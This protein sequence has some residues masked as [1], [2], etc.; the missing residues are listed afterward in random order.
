MSAATN[1]LRQA[2]L[3]AESEPARAIER[4]EMFLKKARA[5]G[6]VRG[7]ASVAR[8]AGSLAHHL[9]RFREASAYYEEALLGAPHDA[10]LFL[11]CGDALQRAGESERARVALSRA[12]EL[13]LLQRDEDLADVTRRLLEKPV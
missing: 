6:D 13:A 5:D 3:M 4:L 12:L 11:A 7:V 10:C 8:H 2:F 9:D 1:A